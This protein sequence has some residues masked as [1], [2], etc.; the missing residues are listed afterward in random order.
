[1]PM[2]RFRLCYI[3]LSLVISLSLTPGALTAARAA[4]AAQTVEIEVAPIPSPRA[5]NEP[6][7]I[8]VTLKQDGRP[9]AEFV[10]VTVEAVSLN[11][12][13][14]IHRFIL[15]Q[16]RD[17]PGTHEG[18]IASLTIE[19]AYAITVTA[20]QETGL[21]AP[22]RE[23]SPAFEAYLVPA[24]GIPY[25]LDGQAVEGQEFEI[26][27]PVTNANKL[28][29]GTTLALYFQKPQSN[30][31]PEVATLNLASNEFGVKVT[32]D[33]AAEYAIP[34]AYLRAKTIDGVAFAT[35]TKSTSIGVSINLMQR[36]PI[37]VSAIVLVCLF[38]FAAYVY[39]QRRKEQEL[40]DMATDLEAEIRRISNKQQSAQDAND[41]S[42]VERGLSEIQ[43][44][45]QR[46]QETILDEVEKPFV[47]YASYTL[48]D[49][50]A[51]GI[52]KL[53]AL[54]ADASKTAH[55]RENLFLRGVAKSVAND[56][57]K[58]ETNVG[59]RSSIFKRIYDIVIDRSTR[60]SPYDNSAVVE[61]ARVQA[62]LLKAI[63][64]ELGRSPE[65]SGTDPLVRK[66][67]ILSCFADLITTRG[68]PN[69]DLYSAVSREFGITATREIYWSEHIALLYDFMNRC[70]AHDFNHSTRLPLLDKDLIQQAEAVRLKGY[71][72]T[73]DPFPSHF[74]TLIMGLKQISG[75]NI[76]DKG[77]A[78]VLEKLSVINDGPNVPADTPSPELSI[79]RQLHAHWSMKG[80]VD[81]QWNI[82][83]KLQQPLENLLE[84]MSDEIYRE[85]VDMIRQVREG[86]EPERMISELIRRIEAA[87]EKE[88]SAETEVVKHG[89]EWPARELLS[90]IKGFLSARLTV[91]AL[92]SAL[93]RDVDCDFDL[94]VTNEGDSNAKDIQLT[95]EPSGAQIQQTYFESRPIRSKETWHLPIQ[96]K[97]TA[98]Q[99]VARILARYSD[100]EKSSD[101]RGQIQL[102]EL[103]IEGLDPITSADHDTL[104]RRRESLAAGLSSS[105]LDRFWQRCIH[106]GIC[107]YW[108]R[109]CLPNQGLEDQLS[110][111][112][113]RVLEAEPGV[114]FLS[115]EDFKKKVLPEYFADNKV[116]EHLLGGISRKH[117]EMVLAT[118]RVVRRSQERTGRFQAKYHE[119][120]SELGSMM[121]DPDIGEISQYDVK[122]LVEQKLLK[123]VDTEYF[124][125]NEFL[126]RWLNHENNVTDWPH[127]HSQ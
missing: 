127:P 14:E 11:D 82:T 84:Q 66:Q 46:K 75:W 43:E 87:I 97:L 31:L 23:I 121:E 39:Q 105:N 59:E 101:E 13:A 92:I 83:E 25:I 9:L 7:P 20:R 15:E 120:P 64:D 81:D 93:P 72:K 55:D 52:Q 34:P 126:L 117:K 114:V 118:Y 67:R 74:P 30:G 98:A 40:K 1:M 54:I 50:F 44:K 88:K 91:R 48:R 57:R 63:A 109:D 10:E 28:E 78:P 89:Q 61:R 110:I 24:L 47:G 36:A 4:P 80:P 95:L 104:E 37:W 12:P 68:I 26:R 27:V 96:L 90:K 85:V 41:V 77:F 122:V 42:A 35:E 100:A 56:L 22:P 5:L 17:A 38:V 49:S 19:G 45:T 115:L 94:E 119:I 18:K 111:A 76:R 62:N 113:I 102:A 106:A 112:F 125:L 58:E 60:R 103:K 71:A 53:L 69:V 116:E 51:D 16:R 108:H 8:T 65:S 107:H 73:D 29:V 33:D 3:S 70:F 21:V 79:V 6:V 99:A 123:Q 2:K 86:T 124:T 32:L